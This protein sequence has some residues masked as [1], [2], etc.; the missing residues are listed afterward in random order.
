MYKLI[1]IVIPVFMSL[2]TPL[3]VAEPLT[4]LPVVNDKCLSMHLIRNA[5]TGY[6]NKDGKIAGIHL[7]FLTALEDRS[8]LC[9]DK[10][11]TPYLR[12]R[13]SIHV[14]GHDGGIMVRSTELDVYIE[15][16]V[17]LI[18]LRTVIIPKAGVS[19]SSYED[20]SELM[21]GRVRGTHLNDIF[22][23]DEKLTIVELLN[24]EHGLQLL[25]RGR[26]DAIA[27]SSLGL[28][29]IGK[30]DMISDVNLLGKLV[31]GEKELWLV[32]SKK[33]EKL[34]KIEQLKKAAQGLVDEG[35]FDK[36]LEKYYGA[37]WQLAN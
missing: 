3:L 31:L 28:S 12:A 2:L 32:L 18:T 17:K 26:I 27:G 20:L 29:I 19:L 35:V 7:E 30:F 24:Y 10:K 33:S 25:K 15:P 16:I 4:A 36:I 1:S 6:I 8:G 13:K 5:P 23:N 14:G 34:N 22:D 37:D 11:L 9:I 21:I